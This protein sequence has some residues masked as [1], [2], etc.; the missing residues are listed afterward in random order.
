MRIKGDCV[1]SIASCFAFK[2][3]FSVIL[4]LASCSIEPTGTVEARD[5]TDYVVG[6]SLFFVDSFDLCSEFF[7]FFMPGPYISFIGSA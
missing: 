6:L 4:E 7:F 3:Y 2:F 5:L 1:A